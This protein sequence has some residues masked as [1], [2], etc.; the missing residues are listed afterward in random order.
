MIL[1]NLEKI[2]VLLMNA[3]IEAITVI[4]TKACLRDIRLMAEMLM[5]NQLTCMIDM[6]MT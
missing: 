5:K 1:V 6:N 3:Q 2:S 4:V